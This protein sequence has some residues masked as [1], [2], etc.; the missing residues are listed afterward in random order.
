MFEVALCVHISCSPEII[1][2]LSVAAA[3]VVVSVTM[4][5]HE[6]VRTKPSCLG[7]SFID[8]KSTQLVSS[9]YIYVSVEH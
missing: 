1:P 8:K 5:D 6:G 9:N 4:W 3:A 7:N 2:D